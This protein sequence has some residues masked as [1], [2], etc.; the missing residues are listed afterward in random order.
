MIFTG[1]RRLHFGPSKLQK[2]A[3]IRITFEKIDGVTP[4]E[5][6]K[7]KIRTGYENI[8]VHMI[9]DIKMD[10]MFTRKARLVADGHTTSP[11]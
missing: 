5:M 11:P 1:N 9:F 6:S 4:Y 8:N 7:V 2:K 3:N 10:G